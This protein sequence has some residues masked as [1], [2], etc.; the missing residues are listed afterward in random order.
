[1]PE[2]EGLLLE[3]RVYWDEGTLDIAH[4][5]KPR[6]VTF[7]ASRGA[8]FPYPLQRLSPPERP[9]TFPLVEPGGHYFLLAF[10]PEMEGIVEDRGERWTLQEMVAQERAHGLGTKDR[11]F[12]Y[13][14]TPGCRAHLDCAPIRVDLQF[15]PRAP[16]NLVRAARLGGRLG[17]V[18][19]LDSAWERV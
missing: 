13:P 8:D 4:V 15:V 18:S 2:S 19:A 3:I 5:Q 16:A 6:R 10:L 11:R 12:Y 14:L 7:G 17:R 9:A 1:M